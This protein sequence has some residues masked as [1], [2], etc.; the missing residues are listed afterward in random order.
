MA[1]RH[2]LV[3]GVLLMKPYADIE[4]GTFTAT[5]LDLLA[6]KFATEHVASSWTP[7]PRPPWWRRVLVWL[8]LSD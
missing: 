2:V 6:P 1:V 7:P 3:L 4:E 8:G 5:G